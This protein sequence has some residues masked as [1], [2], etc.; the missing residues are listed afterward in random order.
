MF[1]RCDDDTRTVID[2]AVAESQR[3]GHSWIGTEHVLVALTL[4]RALL[5]VTVAD[6]LPASD[7]VRG[8][9][10]R[11]TDPE[12]GAPPA[13]LLASLGIDLGRVRTA[14]RS[15]FGS[16]ALDRLAQRR[17]HQPWQPW[18]RP[19]RGCVSVLAG[20]QGVAP[21]LKEALDRAATDAARRHRSLVDPTALLLGVIE[22]QDAFAN[23]LLAGLGVP[24]TTLHAA[25]QAAS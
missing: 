7:R 10:A 5:P 16:E 11:T 17:V 4:H 15:T 2:A 12:A 20:Y 9:L 3:L 18:R 1:D 25:I 13:E 6:L 24:R 23:R 21:R 14:V 19:T 8:A 22:V